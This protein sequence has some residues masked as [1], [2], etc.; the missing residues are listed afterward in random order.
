MSMVLRDGVAKNG[1]LT[2][3]QG[4][5]FVYLHGHHSVWVIDACTC[6]D[7]GLKLE[8]HDRLC[9]F[10]HV[11]GGRGWWI[12]LVLLISL[13]PAGGHTSLLCLPIRT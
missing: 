5:V 6:V 8:Q 12:D 13:I 7:S 2:L 9:A 4:G 10:V 11:V 1:V 3:E